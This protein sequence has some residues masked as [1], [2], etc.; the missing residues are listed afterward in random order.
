MSGAIPF[1]NKIQ[2][3]LDL[4]GPQLSMQSQPTGIA[5]SV[6]SGIGT[7]V[8]I[9]T[10]IYPPGQ[11]GRD[12]NTGTVTHQWHKV[13]VGA[14]T[15]SSNIVG[16]A[17][18]TLTVKGLTSPADRQGSYFC[19]INYTPNALSPNAINEP[20]DSSTAIIGVQPTL[21][22]D[23]Q[24][25]D[26]TVLAGVD[27]TFT[28]RA[29]SSDLGFGY[30]PNVRPAPLKYQWVLDGDGDLTD[31]IKRGFG[32]VSGSQSAT[33]SISR[34]QA[35]LYK[36]FCRVS[37]VN[38]NPGIITSSLAKL[39]VSPERSLLKF[40]RY[41]SGLLTVE[42]EERDLAKLG[43]LAFRADV[44]K[45]ARIICVHA[46]EEDVDVKI[47]MGAAAGADRAIADNPAA[48]FNKGGEG[49]ISVFKHTMKKGDEYIIKLGVNYNQGGGP[50]GGIG[51]GGGIAAIYHKAKLIA[52]C[53]GGGAAGTRGSG[54]DGG[55]LQVQGEDAQGSSGGKGGEVIPQGTIPITGMTQAGR[56]GLRDFDNGSSGSGRIS[57][58]TIG[59]DYWIARF[60]PCDD[61]GLS[62]F[63][64]TDGSTISNSTVLLRGYKPGQGH[65]NN[66]GAGYV[67]QGGG[68]AGARGGQAG[69]NDG[70]G[71]GGA[72]GYASHEVELL[73]SS[74]LPSGTQLGGNTGVAFIS[75]EAFVSTEDHIPFIP[76]PVENPNAL[77]T[78]RFSVSR[79][80]SDSNTVTFS[81]QSGEGPNTLTFGPNGGEVTA[82]MSKGAVYRRTS[83]TASG[84]RGLTMR[85]SGN[86]LQ[87]DDNLD[88][89]FN[90]L[91]ITPS[92]GTF[93][94]LI[95]DAATI[96]GL[97]GPGF[98][99]VV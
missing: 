35:A 97:S 21:S 13:G 37:H 41:S 80:A 52:V 78:V 6:A 49:G 73:P 84:G 23:T 22:I 2:S 81:K 74:Q 88:A 46:P 36:V 75:F 28:I 7:L 18:T 72:S 55:G 96:A 32:D 39:D 42:S 17:T 51:G 11:G 93:S 9:G 99:Y 60:A 38:T 33:L 30:G 70:D 5:V 85:L 40:E 68:G 48:G 31:G 67:N 45:N 20:F 12:T 90:D 77:V 92:V 86:T 69:T 63:P 24:P 8:A 3:E 64:N 62:K 15:D 56:T 79:S 87:I 10:A 89:D 65:R 57:G 16:S 61:I 1:F 59:S 43:V 76:P 47:S 91:Q 34:T 95:A 53:G 4:N 71:G 50:R 26:T 19:R 54:G 58:C 44:D 94:T 98:Q 66:G 29:S 83:F 27:A 14:L 82:Q 25:V